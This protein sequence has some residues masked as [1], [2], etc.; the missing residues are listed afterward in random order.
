MV[1]AVRRSRGVE[2]AVEYVENVSVFSRGVTVSIESRGVSTESILLP[3]EGWGNPDKF[4]GTISDLMLTVEELVKVDA[5][6]VVIRFVVSALVVDVLVQ[7]LIGIVFVADDLLVEEAFSS[8][9]LMR[10]VTNE[11]WVL[12]S[13]SRT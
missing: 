13:C 3:T 6:V 12:I 9:C 11:P 7:L 4:K 5:V 2:A 10:L 8:Y 1:V